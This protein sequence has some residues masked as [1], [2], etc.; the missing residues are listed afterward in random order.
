MAG[1]WLIVRVKLWVAFVPT[2]LVA[3]KV[4]GY[5]PPVPAAGVPLKTPVPTLNVTPPGNVPVSLKAGAGKP[6][7]VTVN[8]PAVAMV[9]VV[10]LAL[11]MAGAWLIVRVKLW[12]AF[13]PTPLVAV[14]VME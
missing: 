11:V 4:I 13:V 3:V 7:A 12:V 9:K 5:V 10:L 14:K 1:A 6:V 8:V 2:P